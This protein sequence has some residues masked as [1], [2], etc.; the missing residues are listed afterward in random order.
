M[1]QL[2]KGLEIVGEWLLG[3][4]SSKTSEDEDFA[5]ML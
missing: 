2:I 1:T 5:G 3:E 4:L